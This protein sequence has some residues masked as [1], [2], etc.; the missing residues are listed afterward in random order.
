[1]LIDSEKL[2]QAILSI[3]PERSEVLLI[4]DN[5]PDAVVRC[6]DCKLGIRLETASGKIYM[7]DTTAK[8]HDGDWYCADGKRR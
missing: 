6:A 3:M 4:V 1:M 2:T 5:Q 8:C 7:C